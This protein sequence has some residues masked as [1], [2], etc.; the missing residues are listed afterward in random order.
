MGLRRFKLLRNFFLVFK[1]TLIE[2][3]SLNLALTNSIMESTFP[4]VNGNGDR[5]RIGKI[6][7]IITIDT[8]QT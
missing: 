3:E 4:F 6:G 2:G 7:I 1:L 8:H 5:F